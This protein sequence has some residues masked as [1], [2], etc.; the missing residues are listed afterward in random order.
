MECHIKTVQHSIIHTTVLPCICCRKTL[1]SAEKS[2]PFFDLPSPTYSR[3]GDPDDRGVM[4]HT[5][6]SFHDADRPQDMNSGPRYHVPVSE[7]PVSDARI[8]PHS[9]PWMPGFPVSLNHFHRFSSS[10]LRII[11]LKTV[12]NAAVNISVMCYTGTALS[13]VYTAFI[14][15]AARSVVTAFFIICHN[16]TSFLFS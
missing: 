14:R 5:Q 11:F 6:S 15:A 8:R 1:P 9:L 10:V 3:A 2:L 4:S 12:W 16:D 13:M 7:I